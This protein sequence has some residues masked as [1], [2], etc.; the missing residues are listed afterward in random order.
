[1]I[2][3]FAHGLSGL[4]RFSGRDARGVFWPY[5][6]LVVILTLGAVTLVM[7]S[8]ISGSFERT[9][10]YALEHPD[11]AQVT[12]STG[13]VAIEVRGNHPELMPDMGRTV[14]STAAV[15]V[16]LV[17]L[18]GAAVSRRLHDT[19]RTGLWG[20]P[21]V[22]FLGVG[23]S[24]FPRLMATFQ[25]GDMPDMRLFFLLFANNLIYLGTLGLLIAF[26]AQS[27]KADANRYGPPTGAGAA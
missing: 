26:L 14:G 27:G 25:T 5:A 23:V 9:A 7:G 1:M 13:G 4:T 6:L 2:R 12:Y 19:G 22:L 15:V 8:E 21:P 20:L 10:K 17:V 16:A 3:S 24:L 18:L 11:Q